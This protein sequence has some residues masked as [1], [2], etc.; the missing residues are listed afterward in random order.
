MK[1]K[2][3]AKKAMLKS[4]KSE[5]KSMMGEGRNDLSDMLG[6]K[7]MKVEVDA[8]SKEGLKEGLSKAEEIMNSKLG[9]MSAPKD[10][11]SESEYEDCPVCEGEGCEECE[12]QEHSE[13]PKEESIDDLKSQIEMLKKQLSSKEE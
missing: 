4:L 2:L 12:M 7:K 9:P 10:D 11:E 8:D 5:M 1:D 6:K 3:E 13:E